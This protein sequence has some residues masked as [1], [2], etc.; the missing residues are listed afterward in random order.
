MLFEEAFAHFIGEPTGNMLISGWPTSAQDRWAT[1]SG[2]T[3]YI[4][5]DDTSNKTVLHPSQQPSWLTGIYSPDN[6]EVRVDV[7]QDIIDVMRAFADNI[8][9]FRNILGNSTPSTQVNVASQ[10]TETLTVAA[11]HYYIVLYVA[12]SNAN[13]QPAFKLTYTPSAGAA[14]VFTPSA[15]VQA[16]SCILLGGQAQGTGVGGRGMMAS[17]LEMGPA[18]TLALTDGNFVAADVMRHDFIFLDYTL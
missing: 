15:Q 3:N 4:R 7:L 1:Q 13:R 6:G 16:Q 2:S 9:N 5:L 11:G 8:T 18:D 10:A 14:V 17:G 12:G